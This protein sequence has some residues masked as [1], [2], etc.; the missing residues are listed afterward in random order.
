M[1][2]GIPVSKIAELRKAA[3]LTQR[4]LAD[5]VSVTESTIRNWEN[6]RSGIDMFVAISRLCKALDCQPDDLIEFKPVSED[7]DADA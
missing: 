6:N 3:G 7:N 2:D 5:T 4:Q 1:D